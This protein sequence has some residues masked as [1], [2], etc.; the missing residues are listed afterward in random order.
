MALIPL[1]NVPLQFSRLIAFLFNIYLQFM[2]SPG[3]RV[4]SVHYKNQLLADSNSIRQH[5]CHF[6]IFFWAL[7][8]AVV[9][10]KNMKQFLF[11]GSLTLLVTVFLLTPRPTAGVKRRDSK[12]ER[13]C[14]KP[15]LRTLD[16]KI[17]KVQVM[18][19]AGN[20]SLC[21]RCFLF[22][23]KNLHAAAMRSQRKRII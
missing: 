19:R 22:S 3:E 7:A 9:S 18:Y 21:A 14:S 12:R 6:E 5:R 4:T 20:I 17:K 8:L 10:L 15:C 11:Y 23:R 1:E 2:W 13:R 16:E